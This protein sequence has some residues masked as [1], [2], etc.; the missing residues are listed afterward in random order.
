[1]SVDLK[2]LA[3]Q[4]RQDGMPT[5][6]VIAEAIGADQGFVSLA[7]A[8]KLKRTTPRVVALAQ[9]V[10][11]RISDMRITPADGMAASP[12]L[13]AESSAADCLRRYL[14]DGYDET[15]VIEQLAVLR[16]AQSKSRT[17]A[18]GVDG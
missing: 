17:S 10:S 8:G 6:A 16:R 11:S 4:L 1:M 2:I 12:T 9:Y 5:Q 15:I 13:S 7:K 18:M 14:D 3:E